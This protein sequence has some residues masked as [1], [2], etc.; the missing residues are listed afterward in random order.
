MSTIPGPLTR[1]MRVTCIDGEAFEADVIVHESEEPLRWNGWIAYPLLDRAEA[2]RLV[3]A[4]NG[5]PLDIESSRF[6]WAGDILLEF[7]WDGGRVRDSSD[8]KFSRWVH[9]PDP[10]GRYAIGVMRWCWSEVLPEGELRVLDGN[11]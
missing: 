3:K 5:Q 2:E 9:S 6:A 7:E 4:L 11:R 10:Q 1:R 8:A